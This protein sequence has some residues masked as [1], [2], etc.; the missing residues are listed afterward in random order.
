MEYLPTQTV[1]SSSIEAANATRG[2]GVNQAHQLCFAGSAA[3]R[4]RTRKSNAADGSIIGSSS[5]NACTE[6]NSFTRNWHGAHVERC[7]S[8]SSRSPSFRR[9][10]TYPRI[11]FSIRLQLI[12]SFLLYPGSTALLAAPREGLVPLAAFRTPGRAAISVRSPNNPKSLKSLRNP[13]P[14]TCAAAPPLAASPAISQSHAGSSCA[15]HPRQGAVRC[16][17]ASRRR[18][19][20]SRRR[21]R[22]LQSPAHPV[23][24][25]YADGG[26]LSPN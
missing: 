5:S 6:R 21:P 17:D 13:A 8:I 14:G 2:D 9:P 20:S 24:F 19:A 15:A 7:V 4:A 16:S 23:R 18:P 11:L 22:H 1:A 26:C 12:T 3:T 25:P 10:S